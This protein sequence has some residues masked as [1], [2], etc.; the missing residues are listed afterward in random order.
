VFAPRARYR[1]DSGRLTIGVHCSFAAGNLHATLADYQRRFPKIFHGYWRD[2]NA[3]P[4]LGPFIAMFR[5]RYPALL[6]LRFLTAN[7]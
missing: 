5:E 4:V 1:G 2:G 6:R 3:N 7:R